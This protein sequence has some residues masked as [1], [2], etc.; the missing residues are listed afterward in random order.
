MIANPYELIDAKLEQIASD[1]RTLKSR[2]KEQAPEEERGGVHECAKWT[3]KAQSTIY[4]H[5]MN[6][7]IPFSKVHGKLYFKKS[8]ILAWMDGAGVTTSAKVELEQM[9]GK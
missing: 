7:T 2:L 6:K 8:L 4:K 3:G 5:V 1:V 9:E